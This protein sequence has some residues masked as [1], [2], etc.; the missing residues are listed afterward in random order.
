LQVCRIQ[1]SHR[2]P[3]GAPSMCRAS[4]SFVMRTIRK[5]AFWFQA[6]TTEERDA[7][8]Q[9]WKVAIA[10]LATL[11]VLEDTKPLLKEFFLAKEKDYH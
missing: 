6:A 9:E 3:T 7:L 2:A 1:E 11:A 5:E 8:V 10:R 4:T